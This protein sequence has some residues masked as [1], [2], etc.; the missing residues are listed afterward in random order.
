MIILID[1]TTTGNSLDNHWELQLSNPEKGPKSEKNN[2]PLSEGWLQACCAVFLL[3]Y[4]RHTRRCDAYSVI[5][6][7]IA[8]CTYEYKLTGR[9]HTNTAQYNDALSCVK[10]KFK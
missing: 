7:W 10:L 6:T 3:V 4:Y 8:S 9:P 1:K 5:P 2:R